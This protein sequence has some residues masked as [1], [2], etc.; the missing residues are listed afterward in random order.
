MFMKQYKLILL[1][2]SPKNTS[3]SMC[4]NGK[5][6]H[7]TLLLHMNRYNGCLTQKY[8]YDSVVSWT[9]HFFH[10]TPFFLKEE[11][12]IYN[13]SDLVIEQAFSQKWTKW[14]CHFK[15]S[16]VFSICFQWLLMTML[17]VSRENS[18]FRKCISMSI[19]SRASST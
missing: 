13:N 7:T 5:Y 18:N 3:S 12:I 17:R 11:L 2:L 10:G 1:N 6:I 8:L 4:Q 9:S 14:A 15:E 19:I 16:N